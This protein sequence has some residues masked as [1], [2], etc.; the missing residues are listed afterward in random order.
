MTLH[1]DHQTLEL[2]FGTNTIWRIPDSKRIASFLQPNATPVDA[3]DR[4]IDA[5]LAGPLDF[6]SVDQAVVPG[7]HLVLAVESTVPSLPAVSLTTLRWFAERGTSPA[8]M[9]VVVAGAA[10]KA[11]EKLTAGIQ[12]ELQGEVMVEVHDPDDS[13]KVAY[14]AAND[15]SEPIYVNRTVVDADVVLPITRHRDPSA[16]DYFGAC[17]IFPWLSDRSTRSKFGSLERLE[18]SVAREPL[19]RWADQAAQWTGFMVAMQL[20]PGMG[21]SV[22]AVRAGALGAIETAN[23]RDAAKYWAVPDGPYQNV[24]AL[25]DGG[26]VQDNWQGVARALWIADRFAEDG[27]VIV[28]C[29]QS[30][31]SLGKSLQRLR[32]TSPTPESLRKK[33]SK[34]TGD[35]ALIAG[36]IHRIAANKH[37]Y[38]VSQARR[39]TVESVGLGVLDSQEELQRLM[40][41]FDSCAVLG[42]AQNRHS[43]PAMVHETN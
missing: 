7:D 22:L 8:N 1:T 41:Q 11:V 29:T 38:L 30:K 25:V 21:D 20:I 14:V 17:S 36:L 3:L 13:E 31:F 19:I 26:E 18:P 43:S 35:D 10:D 2:R 24:V 4:S 16:I 9:K 12:A 39:D 40:S 6:P 33:L 23:Q 5:C 27:G 15:E 37:I 32:N 34:D 28:I 42:S